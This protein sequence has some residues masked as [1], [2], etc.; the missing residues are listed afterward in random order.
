VYA[1]SNKQNPSAQNNNAAFW[2]ERGHSGRPANWQERS[3]ATKKATIEAAPNNNRANQLNPTCDVYWTS[4]GLT[5]PE[6][7]E[8]MPDDNDDYYWGEDD[9]E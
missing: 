4:R 8:D 5:P 1:G 3:E 6:T 9:D 2:R 7:D